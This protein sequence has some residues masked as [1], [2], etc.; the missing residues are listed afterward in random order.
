MTEKNPLIEP[1]DYLKGYGPSLEKLKNNPAAVEFDKL[2]FEVFEN[3]DAGKKLMELIL[4]RYLIPSLVHGDNKN[5]SDA[6]VW[7]EGFKAA[8]RVLRNSALSHSQR[9]KAEINK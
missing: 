5:Y 9:I 4:E 3:T 6:C 8:F 7:A 2:C 1:Y